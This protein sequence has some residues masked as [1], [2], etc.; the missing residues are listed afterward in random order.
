MFLAASVFSSRMT[1][2]TVASGYLGV[3]LTD[4]SLASLHP[5]HERGAVVSDTAA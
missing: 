5:F 1:Y 2:F 3:V 4:A